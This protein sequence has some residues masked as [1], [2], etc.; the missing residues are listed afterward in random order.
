[1]WRSMSRNAAIA[2]SERIDRIG[3]CGRFH[4][5][6]KPVAIHHIHA[7]LKQIGNVILQTGVTENRNPRGPI[8]FDHDVGVAFVTLITPRPRAKKGSMRRHD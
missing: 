2:A 8:K 6:L 5:R 1:M 4:I 3:C 7:A